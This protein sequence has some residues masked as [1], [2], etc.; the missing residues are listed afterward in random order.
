M[1]DSWGCRGAGAQEGSRNKPRGKGNGEVGEEGARE[2]GEPPG[3]GCGSAV[4]QGSADSRGQL[5]HKAPGSLL[6]L[7]THAQ[8]ASSISLPVRSRQRGGLRWPRVETLLRG[9]PRPGSCPTRARSTALGQTTPLPRL[10]AQAEGAPGRPGAPGVTAHTPPRESQS[11]LGIPGWASVGGT[12]G[13][14]SWP[15]TPDPEGDGAAAKSLHSQEKHLLIVIQ[16]TAR[17]STP[18]LPA[19]S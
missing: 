6:I 1:Q 14:R 17:R 11:L 15:D 7:A 18:G 19:D 4:P 10:H 5:I 8:F 12:M 2:R 16:T 3:L 9:C 13:P